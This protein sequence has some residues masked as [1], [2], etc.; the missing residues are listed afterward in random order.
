ML[1]WLLV[2]T[3]MI[4]PAL[5]SRAMASMALDGAAHHAMMVEE[6]DHHAHHG[7][8]HDSSSDQS[9]HHSSSTHADSCCHA[10]ACG[11]ALMVEAEVTLAAQPSR[12]SRITDHSLYD[13]DLPVM[14]RPPRSPI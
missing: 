6:S 9:Q 3:M 11:P 1:H 2:I 8:G 14:I 5:F 13:V 7:M 4:Q 12:Y 10:P